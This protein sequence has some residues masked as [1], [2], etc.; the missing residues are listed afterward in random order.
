MLMEEHTELDF[1]EAVHW[2]INAL[3]TDFAAWMAVDNVHPAATSRVGILS[4]V[5]CQ[6]LLHRYLDEELCIQLRLLIKASSLLYNRKNCLHPHYDRERLA[7]IRSTVGSQFLTNLETALKSTALAKA[8]KEKLMGLFLVLLGA[9]IAITY[10]TGTGSEEARCEL[11]RILAH[12]TIL[13]AERISLIDDDL[14][15]QRLT[16]SCQNLWNKTGNFVWS[17]KMVSA[18]ESMEFGAS[19][20]PSPID[21]ELPSASTAITAWPRDR[22]RELAKGQIEIIASCNINTLTTTS[23]SPPSAGSVTGDTET[24]PIYGSAESRQP[25][26]LARNGLQQ[27]ESNIESSPMAQYPSRLPE[28]TSRDVPPNGI[29]ESNILDFEALGAVTA[30]TEDV[31]IY[32]NT[33]PWQPDSLAT[34][35]LHG[36][37]SSNENIKVKRNRLPSMKPSKKNVPP[38]DHDTADQTDPRP[39]EQKTKRKLIIGKSKKIAQKPKA[40]VQNSP[41]QNK[42]TPPRS[43]ESVPEIPSGGNDFRHIDPARTCS[44]PQ[45]SSCRT[46]ESLRR[47]LE[48]WTCCHCKSVNLRSLTERCPGPSLV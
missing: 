39:Q 33:E 45:C 25:D 11:L 43:E 1:N 20:K 41:A 48:T 17:Y 44:H 9:I 37:D 23:F 24:M 21:F 31:S 28:P 18:V 30:S 15:K 38:D 4:S 2:D 7:L 22:F 13:I 5:E 26:T 10:T 14:T 32:R 42:K 6:G 29:H 12:H 34:N 36:P 47:G 16:T 8:S 46:D 27:A 3:S 40:M 35:S 19:P